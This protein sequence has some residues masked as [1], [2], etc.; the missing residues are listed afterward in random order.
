M[1]VL[2]SN[3]LLRPSLGLT[4]VQAE[5]RVS[6]G[7]RQENVPAGEDILR[8]VR[9][10]IYCSLAILGYTTPSVICQFSVERGA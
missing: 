9:D 8:A 5:E 7:D 3:R 2:G 4:P 6:P 10:V 1:A